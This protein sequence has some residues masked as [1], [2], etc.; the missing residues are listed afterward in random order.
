MI[1]FDLNDLDLMLASARTEHRNLTRMIEDL[2]R[3]DASNID[4]TDTLMKRQESIYFLIAKM[5]A[6]IEEIKG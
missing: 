6:K 1:E 2:R 5:Q 3:A 4:V